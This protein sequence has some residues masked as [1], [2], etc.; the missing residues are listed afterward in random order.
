MSGADEM[1]PEELGAMVA[2]FGMMPV[3]EDAVAIV[4]FTPKLVDGRVQLACGVAHRPFVKMSAFAA[5]LRAL[6]D[7]LEARDGGPRG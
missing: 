4:S 3:P 2:D 6:A 5:G 1:T 7:S